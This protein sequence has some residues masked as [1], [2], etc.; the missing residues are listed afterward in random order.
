MFL[1]IGVVFKDFGIRNFFI[2][3]VVEWRERGV[4]LNCEFEV[5]DIRIRWFFMVDWSF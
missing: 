4:W 3:L 1:N 5:G 2:S